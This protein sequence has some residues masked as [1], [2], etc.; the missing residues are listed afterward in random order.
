MK[1]KTAK[2]N[3][4]E[5]MIAR[6]PDT[7][8]RQTL[9]RYGRKLPHQIWYVT[10]WQARLKNDPEFRI[11]AKLDQNEIGVWL[12]IFLKPLLALD[13]RWFDEM[14]EAIRAYRNDGKKPVNP[15]ELRIKLS[16]LRLLAQEPPELKQLAKQ[17]GYTG[18][19]ESFRRVVDSMGVPY[20]K[21]KG[22]RPRKTSALKPKK[23]FNTVSS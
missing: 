16:D 15:D 11:K 23:H 9:A 20:K 7:F 10:N 4:R 3:R 17:V 12:G 19:M 22:G 2:R 18:N 21:N 1:K 14:A 13:D 8:E 6:T 5:G